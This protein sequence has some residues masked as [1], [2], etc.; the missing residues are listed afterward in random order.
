MSND[1]GQLTSD[2]VLE[3]PRLTTREEI[4]HRVSQLESKI[5]KLA[6][7][8]RAL[9]AELAQ[10]REYG[11]KDELAQQDRLLRHKSLGRYFHPG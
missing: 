6:K 3:A 8:N 10:Y 7:A 4:S 9:E 11:T 2:W 5:R 1:M